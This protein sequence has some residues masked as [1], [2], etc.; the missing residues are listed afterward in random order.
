M[1]SALCQGEGPRLSSVW[2]HPQPWR[3][4]S[5]QPAAGGLGKE[6]TQL[7]ALSVPMLLCARPP[8]GSCPHDPACRTCP[9]LLPA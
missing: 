3:R 7:S 8:F 1:E 6:Q 5:E 2:D 4:V 9:R